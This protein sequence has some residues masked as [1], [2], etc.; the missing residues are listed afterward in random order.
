MNHKKDR[1]FLTK[2]WEYLSL[3]ERANPLRYTTVSLPF[4]QGRRSSPEEMEEQKT[5]FLL[6][7]TLQS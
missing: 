5:R 4:R 2:A 6:V 1:P 3:L 7:Q